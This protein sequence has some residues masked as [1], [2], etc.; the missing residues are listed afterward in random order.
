MERKNTIKEGN[1]DYSA[2]FSGQSITQ[3]GFNYLNEKILIGTE[4]GNLH[5]YTP[6]LKF[7]ETKKIYNGI[8]INSMTWS[9]KNDFLLLTSDNGAKILHPETYE[10]ITDL[11]SDYPVYCAQFSP[12]MYDEKNP[13]YHVIMGG[14]ARARDTAFM[15]QGGLEIYIM[16]AIHG[17]VLSR[18]GGHYG[19]IN[20]IHVFADGTGIVTAGEESIVRIYRFDKKYLSDPIFSHTNSTA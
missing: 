1:A 8:P 6:E 10:L 11:R 12:L 20:W 9:K 4:A 7:I 5:I 3:V 15:R 19:P 18:L 13:K 2:V 14:G 16:N 17:N